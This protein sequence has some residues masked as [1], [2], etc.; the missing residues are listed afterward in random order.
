MTD[1]L[2]WLSD[3]A[4]NWMTWSALEALAL[5]RLPGRANTARS[6]LSGV[7]ECLVLHGAPVQRSDSFPV[8]AAVDGT[9]ALY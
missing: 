1:K 5:L 8:T 3:F 2:R 4:P 9:R 7:S 6:Q